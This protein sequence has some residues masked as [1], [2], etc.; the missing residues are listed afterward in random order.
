MKFTASFAILAAF[1]SQAVVSAAPTPIQ[2]DS[3]LEARADFTVRLTPFHFNRK[4]SDI[5]DRT[6]LSRKFGLVTTTSSLR[7]SRPGSTMRKSSN[8]RP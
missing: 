6:A 1:V 3:A 5:Y 2:F 4:L 7:R 8:V